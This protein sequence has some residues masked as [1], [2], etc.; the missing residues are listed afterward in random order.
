MAKTR[1]P[2]VG[3][4]GVRYTMIMVLRRMSPL[5]AFKVDNP[6]E[7]R[8]CRI[9]AAHDGAPARV[10]FFECKRS[11][12]IHSKQSHWQKNSDLK[13]AFLVYKKTQRAY[14]YYYSTLSM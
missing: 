13:R 4:I 1:T 11:T 6:G 5:E 8:S 3:K 14:I 12:E 10:W 9:K 2:L 7:G